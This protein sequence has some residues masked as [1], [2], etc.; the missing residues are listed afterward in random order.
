MSKAKILPIICNNWK[1]YEIG[2]K[3]VLITNR[4]LYVGFG[5]VFGTKIGVDLEWHNSRNFALFHRIL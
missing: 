3:L 2:C 5:L 1:R 4:K